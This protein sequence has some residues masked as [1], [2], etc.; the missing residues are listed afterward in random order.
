MTPLDIERK[1]W[2]RHVKALCVATNYH[3]QRQQSGYYDA[4][5]FA[6][7]DRLNRESDGFT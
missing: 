5:V 1:A 7:I 2:A 4:E 3:F 6:R